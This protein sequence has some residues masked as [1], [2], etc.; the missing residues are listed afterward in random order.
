MGTRAPKWDWAHGSM[1]IDCE[2]KPRKPAPNS[3]SSPGSSEL[4][5]ELNG[6]LDG[7]DY[8]LRPTS[9]F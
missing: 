3:T 6:R 4:A 7:Q 9:P 5:F 8:N 2:L 1:E